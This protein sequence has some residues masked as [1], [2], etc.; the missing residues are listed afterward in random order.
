MK[1][2]L[3]LRREYGEISFEGE[4]LDELAEN[5]KS[6]PDWLNVIDNLVQK[7]EWPQSPSSRR[8][9]LRGIVES[10]GEGPTLI[11][12]KATISDKEAICLLLYANDPAPLQPK[13]VARFLTIS[14]R[15]SAGFGARLS[16]LRNEGLVVK[17]AGAYRLTPHGQRM[18]EGLI[19]KVKG[20]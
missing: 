19:Q 3:A 6:L 5:L 10:T 16:E 12:P 20:N 18:V 8:E 4:S 14:G 1:V 11:L 15:L 9:E 7:S 13:E 17:D 2:K